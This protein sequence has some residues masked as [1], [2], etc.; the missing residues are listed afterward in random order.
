MEFLT[1]RRMP[2][3]ELRWAVLPTATAC[4][5]TVHFHFI[6]QVKDKLVALLSVVTSWEEQHGSAEHG[7]QNWSKLRESSLSGTTVV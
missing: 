7:C 2:A 3:S 6:V 5:C 4:L 1:Q